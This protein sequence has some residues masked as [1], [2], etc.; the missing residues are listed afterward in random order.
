MI[1]FQNVKLIGFFNAAELVEVPLDTKGLNLVLGENGAGKSSR[2]TEALFWGL[3]GKTLRDL[4]SSDGVINKD[5]DTATVEIT[6][7]DGGEKLQILRAKTRGRSQ[8]LEV[9]KL[10]GTDEVV[11]FPAANLAEKQEKLE[12]WLGL[13][14]NTFQNSVI[15]GQGATAL[16]AAGLSD[17]ERKAVFDRICGLDEYDRAF[18][19]AQSQ[20]KAADVDATVRQTRFEDAQA[21]LTTLQTNLAEEEAG[22]NILTSEIEAARVTVSA[23]IEET[24]RELKDAEEKLETAKVA[25]QDAKATRDALPP[26]SGDPEILKDR[27]ETTTLLRGLAGEKEDLGRKL[28]VGRGK[29]EGWTTEVTRLK[30]S[31]KTSKC[32]YCGSTLSNVETVEAMLAA[33]G[34]DLRLEQ[35]DVALLEKQLAAVEADITETDALLRQLNEA[36]IGASLD[37]RTADEKVADRAANVSAFRLVVE[38][39]AKHLT[40]LGGTAEALRR[41]FEAAERNLVALKAELAEK[42]EEIVGLQKARDEAVDK[43]ALYQFWEEGFGPK[44]IKA[45]LIENVLPT[46]N[47][48]I[49]EHLGYLSDGGITAKVSATTSLKK[50]G[51]AERLS[52][53][54]V[55]ASGADLYGGNSGGEKRRIDLAILLALQDLVGSRASRAVNLCIY[56]EVLDALDEDGTTKAVNYLKIR[57][58]GK[59][60]FLISHSEHTKALVEDLIRVG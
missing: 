7:T 34:K 54:V 19:V 27:S 22:L 12:E 33:R 59:P 38:T 58:V 2:Y 40:A 9:R 30:E 52:V 37:R 60:T 11:L 23:Q 26:A 35:E 31:I 49:N 15:F 45:F 14:A 57:S 32:G 29:V 3:Y 48:L 1:E 51:V 41:R 56:D 10:V 4:K 17:S 8:V 47:R 24:Q 18:E 46:L 21:R 50:G 25:L 20:R 13:D 5:S 44:G 36:V 55:N 39:K 16:F 28:R 43:Q 53:D 42:T 6:L